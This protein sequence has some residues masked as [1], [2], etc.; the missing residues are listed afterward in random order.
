[1]AAVIEREP[2]WSK[3]PAKA[4]PLLRQCLVKDPKTRR[5]D[6]ADAW[7]ANRQLS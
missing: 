1:V 7:S 6:I 3:A 5:H 4:R 2:D